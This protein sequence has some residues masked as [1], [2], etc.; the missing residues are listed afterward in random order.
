MLFSS[1]TAV[2]LA[3]PP[4]DRQ[5]TLLPTCLTPIR[6]PLLDA[7]YNP[8]Q[9]S[10]QR[11]GLPALTTPNP[12]SLLSIRYFLHW[13]RQS[14]STPFNYIHSLRIKMLGLISVLSAGL[15]L[16][17][18]ALSRPIFGLGDSTAD[19]SDTGA[20][21][22]VGLDVI[23]STFLR[24]AQFARV[25]YCSS[26]SITAWDCGAPCDALKNITFLQEGGGAFPS[27]LLFFSDSC[28]LT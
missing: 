3:G 27:R 22:P 10:A 20:P 26:P 23:N 14:N 5:S 17:P 18:T 7:L 21:T 11:R 13:Q 28:R 4:S 24:P 1:S 9:S 2:A 19:L 6:S 8:L 25:A 12:L 15:G 16:L